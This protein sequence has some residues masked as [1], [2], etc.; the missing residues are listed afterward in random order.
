MYSKHILSTRAV[1]KFLTSF[2]ICIQMTLYDFNRLDVNDKAM[3]AWNKCTYLAGYADDS[4][5][6]IKLYL[7]SCKIAGDFFIEAW[8]NLSDNSIASI[9][10][11][12]NQE[13]LAPYLERIELVGI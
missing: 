4:Q 10:T 7:A 5:H 8:F 2:I 13:L 1:R 12:R 3:Y 11:F 6:C 9:N